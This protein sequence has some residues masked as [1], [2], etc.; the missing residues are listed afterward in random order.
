MCIHR[1]FKK[2]VNWCSSV[3]SIL[4]VPVK[5]ENASTPQP[6]KT[7]RINPIPSKTLEIN[8]IDVYPSKFTPKMIRQLQSIKNLAKTQ[9]KLIKDVH[10]LGRRSTSI[11]S[12]EDITLGPFES[13]VIKIKSNR[14]LSEANHHFIPTRQNKEPYALVHIPE[15]IINGDNL[16]LPIQNTANKLVKIQKDS[17][18][19][20][21]NKLNEYEIGQP[22]DSD[23]HIDATT[24]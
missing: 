16:W 24:L 18:L 14:Q 12:S 22:A 6:R 5:N 7:V 2:L 21:A 20:I 10:K 3:T 8:S 17:R 23:L 4:R 11:R 19:G 15:G 9:V 1:K 13:S